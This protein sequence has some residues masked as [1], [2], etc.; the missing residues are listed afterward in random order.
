M[1]GRSMKESTLYRP[2]ARLDDPLRD[3]SP[4]E[5]DAIIGKKHLAPIQNANHY[6]DWN[7]CPLAMKYPQ[8]EDFLQQ[9]WIE[10]MNAKAEGRPAHPAAA[11]PKKRL[12]Q[13]KNEEAP[14]EKGISA[15]KAKKFER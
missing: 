7:E 1:G 9:L 6:L 4:P 12:C 13:P 11:A 15:S 3:R 14:W 2:P 10:R 8:W 5:V